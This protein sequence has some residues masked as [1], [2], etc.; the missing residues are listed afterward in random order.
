[1]WLL[2]LMAAYLRM[3]IP[4]RFA[5]SRALGQRACLRSSWRYGCGTGIQDRPHPAQFTSRAAPAW[6][7]VP[8]DDA[9]EHKNTED[10]KAIPEFGHYQSGDASADARD[11]RG[12]RGGG[13]RGCVGERKS[14]RGGATRQGYRHGSRG[15]TLT[16]SLGS[17]TIAMPWVRVRRVDGTTAAWQSETIH[18]IHAAI[19]CGLAS[20]ST[21]ENSP[22]VSGAGVG[23]AVV[24]R[25]PE[26]AVAPPRHGD[27]MRPTP[28]PGRS[29]DGS[30][31]GS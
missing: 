2:N 11:D 12:Q 27:W 31:D 19:A 6:R 3:S 30:V 14:A 10:G 4:A 8:E 21:E 26:W 16:T 15:R 18:S 25:E 28:K 17:T 7:R 5:A 20:I 24:R 13:A 1:M 23:G 29:G 22:T 9:M